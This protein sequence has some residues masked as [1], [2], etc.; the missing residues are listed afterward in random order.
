MC[1][2]PLV[3]D[4]MHIPFNSEYYVCSP[5]VLDVIHVRLLYRYLDE[6]FP[7]VDRVLSCFEFDPVAEAAAAA[8]A[9]KARLRPRSVH[10]VVPPWWAAGVAAGL[11]LLSAVRPR[12]WQ[13]LRRTL[14]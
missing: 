5:L 7:L 11:L 6:N 12:R 1:A 13:V 8:E 10:A 4:I 9:E 2:H 14:C 3:L